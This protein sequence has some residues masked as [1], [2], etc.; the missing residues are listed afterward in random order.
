MQT[1]E[2]ISVKYDI[3]FSENEKYFKEIILEMYN[4][5]NIDDNN[6]NLLTK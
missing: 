4:N 3:Y 2:E 1:L 5:S 6:S